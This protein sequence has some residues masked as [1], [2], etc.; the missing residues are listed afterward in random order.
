MFVCL[1]DTRLLLQSS[2]KHPVG[3]CVCP[4]VICPAGRF[5]PLE[6]PKRKK[7]DLPLAG[8]TEESRHS[9]ANVQG[10]LII[11]GSF[12]HFSAITAFA[13]SRSTGAQY[14][15]SRIVGVAGYSSPDTDAICS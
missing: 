14:G 15:H 8:S 13:S 7:S 6:L 11:P 2:S 3:H 12:I 4:S 5:P 9:C 1:F 10:S